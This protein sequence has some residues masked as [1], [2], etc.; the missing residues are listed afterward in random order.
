MQQDAT[1]KGKNI[2]SILCSLFNDL[3]IFYDV[4]HC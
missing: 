4:E 3:H 2:F 1:L